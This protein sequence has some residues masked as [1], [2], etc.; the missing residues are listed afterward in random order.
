MQIL[1]SN[2][3]SKKQREY[4]ELRRLVRAVLADLP[5]VE[6]RNFRHKKAD[7]HS[8]FNCPVCK[9]WDAAVTALRESVGL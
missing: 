5:Q 8:G 6:C 9:R 7:Y 4:A 3:L 2:P 1:C